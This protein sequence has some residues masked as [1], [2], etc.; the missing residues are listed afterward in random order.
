MDFG[1]LKSVTEHV[2]YLVLPV[3]EQ[4]TS[5][6]KDGL[7]QW[8]HW[9]ATTQ[10]ITDTATMLQIRSGL[11]LVQGDLEA[12]LRALAQ[13]WT[14]FSAWHRN[15]SRGG[16]RRRTAS[17]SN[18]ILDGYLAQSFLQLEPLPRY[19]LPTSPLRMQREGSGSRPRQ[20]SHG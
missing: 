13:W 2:G 3:V 11:E 12:I 5:L 1:K 6:C 19:Q 20:V 18:K 10:D 15:S 16:L 7:G 17:A 8:C 9:G 4:M 14:T